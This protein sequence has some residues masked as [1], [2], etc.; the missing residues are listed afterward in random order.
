MRMVIEVADLGD[1]DLLADAADA[2]ANRFRVAA[3]AASAEVSRL[4]AERQDVRT[5]SVRIVEVLG[6]AGR[7]VETA[8]AVRAAV[9]L[10]ALA[11]ASAPVGLRGD[12]EDR[13]PAGDAA[14]VLEAQVAAFGG[15]SDPGDPVDPAAAATLAALRAAGTDALGPDAD[16]AAAARP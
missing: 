12:V 11:P 14:D 1:L 6:S 9:P 4:R 15:T 7:L 2:E 10:D 3:E 5:R 8:R 13:T 16:P